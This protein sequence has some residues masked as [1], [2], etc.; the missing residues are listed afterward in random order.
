MVKLDL[1]YLEDITGGDEEVMLEMIHLFISDI[2]KQILEIKKSI[3]EN[4]LRAVAANAHKLKPTLQ[5]IGLSEAHVIVK[6]IEQIGKAG[7]GEDNIHS[8]FTKLE[9]K[10]EEFIPALKTYAESIS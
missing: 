10:S 3:E 4:D 5:Y 1:S 7:E 9:E 2:P 8:L 6:E